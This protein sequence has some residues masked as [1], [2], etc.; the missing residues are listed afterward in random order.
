M[1][2]EQTNCVIYLEAEQQM[3]TDPFL[4][5]NDVLAYNVIHEQD[6]LVRINPSY[7]NGSEDCKINTFLLFT[8]VEIDNR[9]RCIAAVLSTCNSD[10]SSDV[11]HLRCEYRISDGSECIFT[12][13]FLHI[14]ISTK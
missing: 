11:A 2:M 9:V 8:F 13:G 12:R 1:H 4:K 10:N 5:I 7:L 14:R 6:A 3:T